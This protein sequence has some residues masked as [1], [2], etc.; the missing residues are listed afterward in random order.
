MGLQAFYARVAKALGKPADS[1]TSRRRESDAES[2]ISSIVPLHP[3]L[4]FSGPLNPVVRTPTNDSEIT[5]VNDSAYI[6]GHLVRS[7][8]R[9][10]ANR[11]RSQFTFGP[12][13]VV[14]CS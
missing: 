3:S 5:L 10:S 14:V 4:S 1:S 12:T 11:P 2:A 9:R 13:R 7:R 6:G 8:N